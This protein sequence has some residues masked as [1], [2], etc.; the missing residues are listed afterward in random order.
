MKKVLFPRAALV[1]PPAAVADKSADAAADRNADAADNNAALT[2]RLGR[3]RH[4]GQAKQEGGSICAA[5]GG[6]AAEEAPGAGGGRRA[7]STR[8]CRS[9]LME[10]RGMP[11]QHGKQYAYRRPNAEVLIS[12]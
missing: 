7:P 4:L 8:A 2:F 5:A 10:Q 6:K 1:F 12:R 3:R 9:T 11:F